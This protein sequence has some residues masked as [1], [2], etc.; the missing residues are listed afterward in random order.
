[1]EKNQTHNKTGARTS[2]GSIQM[3]RCCIDRFRKRKL[4]LVKICCPH[5]SFDMLYSCFYVS[6]LYANNIKIFVLTFNMFDIE[7]EMICYACTNGTE[8][9]SPSL[10]QQVEV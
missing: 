4:R 8:N 1:M 2:Q 10:Q 3:S 6:F 9:R 5:M 7:R